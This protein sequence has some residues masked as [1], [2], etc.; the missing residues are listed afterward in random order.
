[1]FAWNKFL[2]G[3]LKEK[4]VVIML[5][6]IGYCMY[7]SRFEKEALCIG[8]GD[9]GKSTLLSIRFLLRR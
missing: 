3:I 5:Q 6:F 4:D 2:N 9:N 7:K 1:M 8:K